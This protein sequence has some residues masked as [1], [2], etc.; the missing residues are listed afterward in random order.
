M[1]K[2]NLRGTARVVEA[3]VVPMGLAQLDWAAMFGDEGDSSPCDGTALVPVAVGPMAV[4]VTTPAASAAVDPVDVALA[5]LQGAIG[6]DGLLS[7]AQAAQV[8]GQ[9][10]LNALLKARAEADKARAV[11]ALASFAPIQAAQARQRLNVLAAVEQVLETDPRVKA[12]AAAQ[13]AQADMRARE[14]ARLNEVRAAVNAKIPRARLA[15][16]IGDLASA[17]RI[18]QEIKTSVNALPD[19]D[20]LHLT[21]A[22]LTSILAQAAQRVK[23]TYAEKTGQNF[24]RFCHRVGQSM[25][26]GSE[27]RIIALSEGQALRVRPDP[28]PKAPNGM[29]RYL[30]VESM[31]LAAGE[32]TWAK[33]GNS[34]LVK[35]IWD[36][37]QPW[38]KK[39]VAVYAL[40]GRTPLT[41]GHWYTPREVREAREKAEKATRVAPASAPA[42]VV[43]ETVQTVALARVP[44]AVVAETV[45]AETVAEV[46]PAP[47]PEAHAQMFILAPIGN[48][49]G[50]PLPGWT[51]GLLEALTEAGVP[52]RLG[53]PGD[54]AADGTVIAG[55][56]KKVPAGN[57]LELYLTG[58]DETVNPVAFT[59]I[60]C[61]START[62]AIRKSEILQGAVNALH[63]LA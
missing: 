16:G 26:Q 14:A 30:V 62:A 19:A 13:S 48:E 49:D 51:Q 2:H 46:A 35:A 3:K 4:S 52:A 9:N 5:L 55:L 39:A 43:A 36:A 27:D 34:V 24:G 44:V 54:D 17:E 29:G 1:S 60:T 59:P 33:G 8:K 58:C 28:D 32:R 61:T 10:G 20:S 21:V 25:V 7:E 6:V 11:L 57:S 18:L 45:L 42:A 37:E 56:L 63:G 50:Q 40:D 47:A 12:A 23:A 53:Q 31:G 38:N 15:L 22:D 41:M